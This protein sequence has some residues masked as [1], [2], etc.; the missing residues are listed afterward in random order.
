VPYEKRPMHKET[1]K[2]EKRLVEETYLLTKLNAEVRSMPRQSDCRSLPRRRGVRGTYFQKSTGYSVYLRKSLSEL[3][4]ENFHQN[5]AG[6][7]GVDSGNKREGV[8]VPGSHGTAPNGSHRAPKNRCRVPSP[9]PQPVVS[10]V[11]KE[12]ATDRG[13]V[14]SGVEGFVDS[15]HGWASGDGAGGE[16]YATMSPFLAALA[17]GR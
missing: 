16:L 3:I 14:G 1:N 17:G 15:M 10:S 8:G 4:L 7:S 6:S 9:P 11:A 13:G 5:A 2:Y 12:G